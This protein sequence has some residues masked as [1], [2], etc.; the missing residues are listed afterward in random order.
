MEVDGG[1]I[2]WCQKGEQR[3]VEAVHSGASLG[4]KFPPVK[5]LFFSRGGWGGGEGVEI[6][7]VCA[8][9]TLGRGHWNS[10]MFAPM[11][12]T[13]RAAGSIWVWS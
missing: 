2:S 12:H 4:C 9:G 3:R 8:E 7:N 13:N 5:A 6:Q 10:K 1:D 11:G